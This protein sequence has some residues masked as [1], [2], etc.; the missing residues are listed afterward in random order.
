MVTLATRVQYLNW[1]GR[2][3]MALIDGVHRGYIAPTM[4]R[5]AVDHAV[6]ALRAE[7]AG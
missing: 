1:F 3:Y 2:L 7:D 6:R 4:L 5:L